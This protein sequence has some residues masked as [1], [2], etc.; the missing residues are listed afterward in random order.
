M[1]LPTWWRFAQEAGEPWLAAL[2]SGYVC[3]RT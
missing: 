3:T 1:M 2:D